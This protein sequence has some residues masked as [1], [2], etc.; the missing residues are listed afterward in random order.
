MIYIFCRCFPH[1]LH[2]AVNAMIDALTTPSAR[3]NS[4]A[5]FYS[6]IEE[7]FRLDTQNLADALK[8]DPM[9]IARDIVNTIRMSQIRREEFLNLIDYGNQ[10]QKWTVTSNDGRRSI[11]TLPRI[12][13]IRDLPHRWGSGY[14]SLSRMR[15]L[16]Q[17]HIFLLIFS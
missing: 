6:S 1:T 16:R 5:R 13:P 17:V 2:L 8:R 7:P 10:K 11:T 15:L 14:L 9:A 4:T 12:I 3:Q